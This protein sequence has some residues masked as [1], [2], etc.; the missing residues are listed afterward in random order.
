[1]HRSNVDSHENEQGDSRWSLF[2]YLT[3][4]FKKT[5]ITVYYAC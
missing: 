3:Q 5:L 2:L 1:M 4:S